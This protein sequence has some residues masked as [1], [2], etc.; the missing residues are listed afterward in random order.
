MLRLSSRVREGVSGP[1]CFRF[2]G[3]EESVGVAKSVCNEGNDCEFVLSNICSNLIIFMYVPYQEMR[4]LGIP[5][6]LRGS[7]FQ[8]HSAGQARH[9]TVA[10]VKHVRHTTHSST[11][12]L[13]RKKSCCKLLAVSVAVHSCLNES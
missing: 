6:G 8:L 12:F 7:D 1:C 13:Y 4:L 2:V 5:I 10:N 11:V 3:N 9:R